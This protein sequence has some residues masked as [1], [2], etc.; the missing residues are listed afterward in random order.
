MPEFRSFT[1]ETS[2]D[3]VREY[4]KLERRIDRQDALLK[5]H[6]R[7]ADA[8]KSAEAAERHAEAVDAQDDLL[9]DEM[10]RLWTNARQT[11]EKLPQLPEAWEAEAGG[12]C[13]RFSFYE[14]EAFRGI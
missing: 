13:I 12:R 14:I 6:I 8:D 4:R 9:Y 11:D 1:I 7:A 10:R 3:F 2:A 5:A